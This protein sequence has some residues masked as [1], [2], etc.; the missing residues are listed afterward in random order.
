VLLTKLGGEQL[1]TGSGPKKAVTIVQQSGR[2]IVTV[3]IDD[4]TVHT[5]FATEQE[6]RNFE[7]FQIR[8]LGIK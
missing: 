1:K 5:A 8:K 4:S 2:W 3:R 6:A 7:A